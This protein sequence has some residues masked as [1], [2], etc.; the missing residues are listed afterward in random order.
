MN[1][2]LGGNFGCFVLKMQRLQRMS[3]FDGFL[4]L[5]IFWCHFK[6][7]NSFIPIGK[8]I[9]IKK[10]KIMISW[11]IL[12]IIWIEMYAYIL[13][14]AQMIF[15]IK[16]CHWHSTSCNKLSVICHLDCSACLYLLNRISLFLS[17]FTVE[18]IWEFH[19]PL[20]K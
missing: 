19:T 12:L 13:I 3:Y 2:S 1:A 4:S 7:C 5:F 17:P 9:E 14:T 6:T 15:M 11:V 20:W 18:P 16:I 10:I 8:W